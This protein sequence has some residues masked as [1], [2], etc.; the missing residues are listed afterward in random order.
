M[1]HDIRTPLTTLI[2]YLDILDSG[3]Y[4]SQEELERYIGNCKQK[5]L[6][7]KDLS[8]KMFQ[9]FLVFGRDSLEMENETYIFKKRR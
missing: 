3:D 2:G 5:A 1:S 4:R 6:Q 7:L 9:Y 8:D